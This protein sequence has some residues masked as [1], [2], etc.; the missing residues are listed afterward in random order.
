MTGLLRWERRF[1][2]QRALRGQRGRVQLAP[3]GS[4]ADFLPRPQPGRRLAAERGGSPW[5]RVRGAGSGT[6]ADP[7]AVPLGDGMAAAGA[8]SSCFVV[9]FFSSRSDPPGGGQRERER[10]LRGGD[11]SH[12]QQR[13]AKADGV[14]AG[15]ARCPPPGLFLAR[16]GGADVGL[17]E[18]EAKSGI[19]LSNPQWRGGGEEAEL[20]PSATVRAVVS[21]TTAAL[22]YRSAGFCTAPPL[23]LPPPGLLEVL[24]A[25]TTV[26]C[27]PPPPG[28]RSKPRATRGGRRKP[29][30]S[31]R[32]QHRLWARPHGSRGRSSPPPLVSHSQDP[33]RTMKVYGMRQASLWGLRAPG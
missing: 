13:G 18:G 33:G 31:A 9:V 1:G 28:T 16:A 12:L 26:P 23:L 11:C 19:C 22:G 10:M 27:R 3:A 17:L 2:A 32:Y 30:P 20:S 6:T 5:A 25:A 4:G 14:P 21:P 8:S 7:V 15:R 24:G 29:G